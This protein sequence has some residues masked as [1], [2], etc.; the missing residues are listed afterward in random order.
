MSAYPLPT[1]GCRCSTCEWLRENV[2]DEDGE[3]K[4][5]CF[6][7]GDIGGGGIGGIVVNPDF[8][9]PQPTTDAKE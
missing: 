5:E 9:V 4:I 6:G 1:E 7:S 8:F 2:W 3:L